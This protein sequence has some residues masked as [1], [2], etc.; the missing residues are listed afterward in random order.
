MVGVQTEQFEREVLQ[1]LTRVETQVEACR[2]Q[3]RRIEQRLG[4]LHVRIPPKPYNGNIRNAARDISVGIALVTSIS[5][6]VGLILT[7]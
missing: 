5:A 1:R 3:G 4:D 6:V 7:V 2:E